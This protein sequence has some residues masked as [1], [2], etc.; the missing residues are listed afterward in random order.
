MVDTAK[1]LLQNKELKSVV[2]GFFAD[3]T[4]Y[5]EVTSRAKEIVDDGK[6]D[7]SDLPNII[8]LVTTILNKS[9][10]LKVS[11][12][13]MKPLIKMV[14]IRLLVEVKFLEDKENPLSDEQEMYIDS[15]LALLDS[16][17]TLD[18]CFQYLKDVI[19][20]C[21]NN[22]DSVVSEFL[23]KQKVTRGLVK[24]ARNMGVLS[25]GDDEDEKK[26]VEGA[27]AVAVEEE[28]QDQEDTAPVAVASAEDVSAE[29]GDEK[30]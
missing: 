11:K 12:K 21:L 16:K 23:N 19:F 24:T 20:G 15:G 17:V 8:L 6:L 9:P 25:N 29:V 10:K 14:I 13:N 22:E 30:V 5:Y 4:F 3:K 2:E 26:E 28:N 27:M 7:M 1:D 18:G